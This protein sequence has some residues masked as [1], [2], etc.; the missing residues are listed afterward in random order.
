MK[1]PFPF[2]YPAALV[3]L[4][5]LASCG[6]AP[7]EPELPAFKAVMPELLDSEQVIVCTAADWDSS[8]AEIRCYQRSAR[9]STWREAFAIPQAAAGKQGMAWGIGLHGGP[10]GEPV[11]REGDMRSPAGAF[12]LYG[13]FGYAPAEAASIV[14]FPYRQVTPALEGVEN[15]QSAFYNRVVDASAV[16]RNDWQA[17]ETML[18]PDGLYRWGL[19]V[20]HNWQ[21]LPGFG[22]CIFLHVWRG[23]G[24]GTAGYTATAEPQRRPL[25]AGSIAGNARSSSSFPSRS[26]PG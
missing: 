19:I 21:P 1:C 2:A 26:M 10:P 16:S 7:K 17:T 3:S 25:S 22:S 15:P 6:K 18:R 14:N 20:E 23:P 9:G 5:L 4:C 8:A 13:A 24:Q 12:R 11:K